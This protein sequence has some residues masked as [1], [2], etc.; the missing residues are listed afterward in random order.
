MDKNAFKFCIRYAFVT[1]SN[2]CSYKRFAAAVFYSAA[3]VRIH[4]N[5]NTIRQNQSAWY[6]L[7]CR[8]LVSIAKK[9]AHDIFECQ[10]THL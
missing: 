10:K 2:T 9:S 4:T 7:E 3:K 8:F 1:H 5:Q 6:L